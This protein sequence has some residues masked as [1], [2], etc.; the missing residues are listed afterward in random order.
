MLAA[1]RV[2]LPKP[3]LVNEKLVPET[4]PER[5]RVFWRT[6]RE[7]LAVRATVPARLRL[8]VPV[9][10]ILPP[11]VSGLAPV[12]MAAAEVLSSEPAFKVQLAVAAPRAAALLRFNVPAVST[13][14]VPV[15]VLAPESVRRFEVL[16]VREPVP[17]RIPEITPKLFAPICVTGRL[18]VPPV[19][20]SV[21]PARLKVLG[22]VKVTRFSEPRLIVTAPVPM[23]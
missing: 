1:E 11:K 20:A 18:V 23:A 4:M 10:P 9:K 5:V 12:V 8:C 3:F 14:D 13:F 21:P 17:E 6:L 16:T 7:R 2:K 22:A 19:A 15:K